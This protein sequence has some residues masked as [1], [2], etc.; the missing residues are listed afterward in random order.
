MSVVVVT[1]EELEL[2][3]ERAVERAVARLQPSPSANDEAPLTTTQ[4]CEIAQCSEKSLRRACK[5]GLITGA[6]KPPGLDGWRIP[7]DGL[8]AWI[9]RSKPSHAPET[10]I[11]PHAEA[12]RLFARASR[13]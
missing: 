7:S 2:L 10:P 13:R 6:T 12:D 1:P 5:N 4:A 3:V 11:D 8:R 9:A